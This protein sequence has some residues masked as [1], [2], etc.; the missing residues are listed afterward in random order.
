MPKPKK[1]PKKKFSGV[2][3]P[4]PI[5]IEPKVVDYSGLAEAYEWLLVDPMLG[6]QL[7]MHWYDDAS[8]V[9]LSQKP[10]GGADLKVYDKASKSRA[11]GENP[12]STS[13]E[14]LH[15]MATAIRLYEKLWATTP[16]HPRLDVAI[17]ARDAG[18]QPTS[19][20]VKKQSDFL[21][22]MNSVFSSY[23]FKFQPISGKERVLLSDT[24]IGMPVSG[25]A[26]SLSERSPLSIL[27]EEAVVVT[28]QMATASG[29]TGVTVN[30]K[31][32]FDDL[33][34]VLDTVASGV[35]S[36]A[37]VVPKSKKTTA[38]QPRAKGPRVNTSAVD[39]WGIFRKGTV[40]ASVAAVLGD[41]KWH[42][43]KDLRA[44]CDQYGVV[45]RVMYHVISDLRKKATVEFTASKDQVR[46]L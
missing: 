1:P 17:A 13:D 20:E 35:S 16:D 4:E 38:K 33:P 19:K 2:A 29:P 42:K 14:K 43:T 44:I 46:V 39:P 3:P 24:T 6:R 21:N 5:K 31:Q 26:K 25:L 28:R 9:F 37:T 12:G 27:L 10:L 22:L 11:L 34:K 41:H 8:L 40:K 45:S 23:G 7:A 15:A 32:F 18:N 30:A 36:D